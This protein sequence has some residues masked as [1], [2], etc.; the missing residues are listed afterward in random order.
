MK[1]AAKV[2]LS[3]FLA[4]GFVSV[5]FSA[6]PTACAAEAVDLAKSAELKTEIAVPSVTG[7]GAIKAL[8][9]QSKKIPLKIPKKEDFDS[10]KDEVPS[11]VK[12]VVE[13]LNET[14][15]DLTLDDLNAAR[16]AV[17]KLEA[18]L[19]IEKKLTDIA[20]VRQDR[21]EVENP[22]VVDPVP[23]SA[24]YQPP[25][26][27]AMPP[28]TRSFSKGGPKEVDI[29]RIT[30]AAGRYAATYKDGMGEKH[31]IRKGD[32]MKDGSLVKAISR[33]GVTLSKNKKLVTL[34]VKDVNNIF[35][36]K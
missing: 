6:V 29:E 15:D 18:L 19:D 12:D 8:P 33:R 20:K 32:K 27:G 26:M 25:P 21:E 35:G 24:L 5:L 14:T 11:S 9:T 34:R 22:P 3:A 16:A 1:I 28:V 10:L 31:T 7:P 13:R 30:G 36:V 23:M 4:A 17:A 2:S